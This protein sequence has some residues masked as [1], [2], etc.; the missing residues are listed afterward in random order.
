MKMIWWGWKIEENYHVLVN[1]FH[2][3][4]HYK[5]PSCRKIRSVFRDEKK[6]LTLSSLTLHCHLHPV[7]AANCCR[8]YR[9]V[10]DENDL[11]G[12]KNKENYHVLVNQFHGNC[13]YKTPSCRKIRSVFRDVKW[14]FNPFKPDFTLSSSS[15]TSRELLSQFSTCSGWRWF[16][17]GEKLEKIRSVFRDVKWCF[18]PLI[19]HDAL[20][21]HFT[22]LKAHLIFLQQRVLERK[23][24]WNWFTNA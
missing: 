7:Q 21:H 9:L 10:V 17:G 19:L 2:G 4:C 15:T 14:C 20:E 12:V 22:S 23:F 8:N 11:M 16:D 24:P 5:T 3:N 13:H 1:Q 6:A 18:N